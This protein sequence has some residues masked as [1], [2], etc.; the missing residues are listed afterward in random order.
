MRAII[1]E[2]Q[3]NR[4]IDSFITFL[5]EPYKVITNNYYPDSIFWVKYGEII[6]EIEKSENFWISTLIWDKISYQFGLDVGETY[7][8][9]KTWLEKHYGSK[10]IP[11]RYH[12]DGWGSI[13]L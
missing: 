13:D 1:S 2:S 3:Y 11:W 9:I 7:S 5:L 8:V 10:L 12:P 4:L 6:V